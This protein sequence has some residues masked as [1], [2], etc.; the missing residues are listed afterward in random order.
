MNHPEEVYTLVAGL[1]DGFQS[2]DVQRQVRSIKNLKMIADTLGPERTRNEL[3]PYL[4]DIFTDEQQT[5]RALSEE[6]SDFT[7]QIGGEQHSAVLIPILESL[8]S[9][10]DF[11]VRTTALNSF[12]KIIPIL[13]QHAYDKEMFTLLDSMTMSD[14]F[15]QKAAAAALFPTMFKRAS[16]SQKD[17]LL[18][19]FQQLIDDDVVVVR[20]AATYALKDLISIVDLQTRTT[21]LIEITEKLAESERDSLK[22][23]IMEIIIEFAK[24]KD[25]PDS[26]VDS[27]LIPI[28][29]TLSNDES[30]KVQLK[31]VEL[32]PDLLQSVQNQETRSGFI[33]PFFLFFDPKKVELTVQIN[34]A[35]N[36][37][38]FCSLLTPTTIISEIVPRLPDI[39]NES[40]QFTC[41]F[42]SSI[43][44]IAQCLSSDQF[45]EHLKPMIVGFLNDGRPEIRS[46]TITRLSS[47]TPHLE[48]SS[49]LQQIKESI[50]MIPNTTKWRTRLEI[51][52]FIPFI[53][54]KLGRDAFDEQLLEFSVK[55]FEDTISRIRDTL[56]QVFAKISKEFG[57]EWIRHS[58]LPEL[59]RL[60][61][62]ES[63]L[64]RI[65]ILHALSELSEVIQNPD[66]VIEEILPFVEDF[67][68]DPVPNVRLNS[69]KTLKII[70]RTLTKNTTKPVMDQLKILAQDSDRDVKAIATS[71]L[72]GF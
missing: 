38:P 40:V 24:S 70:S 57:I 53:A 7:K 8:A 32:T 56:G 51:I 3:I 1:I 43:M 46:A 9:V 13:P 45:H 19:L 37:A 34:A 48:I 11:K 26:L 63:Y 55:F 39:K 50:D 69:A 58:Y 49:F 20:R 28:Y 15:T 65:S 54:L 4:Q 17:E 68:Q 66:F 47:I 59:S 71:F 14:S 25:F 33:D 5:L 64:V 27:K 30:V 18:R 42:V 60:S 67:V 10:E 44:D 41:A 2:D 72:D 16:P 52:E 61:T 36:L 35:K 12:C 62:H 6:L 23:W 29:N 21:T 22:L 31:V